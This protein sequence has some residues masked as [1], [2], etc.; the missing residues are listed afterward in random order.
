MYPVASA[1]PAI[2]RI[3]REA[4]KNMLS[5]LYYYIDYLSLNV[6]WNYWSCFESYNNRKWLTNYILILWHILLCLTILTN[7]SKYVKRYNISV[8]VESFKFVGIYELNRFQVSDR[9]WDAVFLHKL[10]IYDWKRH[11]K[12][13]LGLAVYKYGPYRAF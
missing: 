12:F 10:D 11:L 4:K 7:V 13:D 8:K 2:C 3:Q 5:N 9:S 1:Y 6:S